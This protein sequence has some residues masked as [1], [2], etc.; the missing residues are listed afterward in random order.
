MSSKRV[1]D[2]GIKEQEK[3]KVMPLHYISSIFFSISAAIHT[4]KF[5]LMKVSRKTFKHQF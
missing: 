4:D 3:F 5:L 1:L 2:K